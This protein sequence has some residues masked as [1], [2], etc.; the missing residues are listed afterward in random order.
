VYNIALE[1]RLGYFLL[2]V[3]YFVV[4]IIPEKSDTLYEASQL[5]NSGHKRIIPSHCGLM[6]S[7]N[8]L[9]LW[10]WSFLLQAQSSNMKD[11]WSPLSFRIPQFSPNTTATL[12]SKLNNNNNNNNNKIWLFD[13]NMKSLMKLEWLIAQEIELK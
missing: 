12:E 6:A 7:V 10:I 4:I 11:Q 9:K 2:K 1:M 8:Q 3:T 13:Y 5:W